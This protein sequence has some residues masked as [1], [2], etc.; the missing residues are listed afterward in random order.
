MKTKE[1][2]WLKKKSYKDCYASEKTEKCCRFGDIQP[3]KRAWIRCHHSCGGVRQ[4][5]LDLGFIP[6]SDVDVIR[7]APFGDPIQCKIANYHVTLRKS[8]ASLIEVETYEKLTGY[9][10]N[11]FRRQRQASRRLAGQQNAGKSTTFNMLTGANQQP[12]TRASRLTKK[13][14]LTATAVSRSRKDRMLLPTLL[15]HP[16]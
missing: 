14:A 12:I 3:G 2:P 6:E 4:R 9:H 15:V 16:P 1:I 7:P 10:D 5:L 11:T 8:E 13:Q